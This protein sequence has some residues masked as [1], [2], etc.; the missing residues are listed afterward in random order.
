MAI[1]AVKLEG[2]RVCGKPATHALE[3]SGNDRRGL[4]CARHVAAEVRRLAKALGED[5]IVG[6]RRG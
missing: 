6:G 1:Y 4:A 5:A 2:C 3:R